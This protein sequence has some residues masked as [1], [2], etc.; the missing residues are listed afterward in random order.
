MV[1]YLYKKGRQTMKNII[2]TIAMFILVFNIKAQVIKFQFDTIQYIELQKGKSL[3]ENVD[4]NL[5]NYSGFGYGRVDSCELN[6]DLRFAVFTGDTVM[7]KKVNYNSDGV[8]I[9]YQDQTE[10]NDYTFLYNYDN[11]K[12]RKYILYYKNNNMSGGIAYVK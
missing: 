11:V 12:K 4:K 6:L 3:K 8:K 9:E 7:I 2:T 1:I 10:F 5:I